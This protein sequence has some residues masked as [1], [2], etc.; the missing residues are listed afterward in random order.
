MCKVCNEAVHMAKSRKRVPRVSKWT[1][2]SIS[3]GDYHR[4]C[5]RLHAIGA[6]NKASRIFSSFFQTYKSRSTKLKSYQLTTTTTNVDRQKGVSPFLDWKKTHSDQLW[7]GS[8]I[9]SK[10]GASSP[11][12]R[13]RIWLV[14]ICN[15]R[16]SPWTSGQTNCRPRQWFVWNTG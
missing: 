3:Y 15:K 4:I 10:K 16:S 9:N 12:C 11:A 2:N 13:C 1:K 14:K 6:K 5:A 8:W 7:P